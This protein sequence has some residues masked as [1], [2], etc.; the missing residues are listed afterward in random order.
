MQL[1][2]L[3]QG[4]H[5]VVSSHVPLSLARGLEQLAQQN[6]RSV[7]GEIRLALRE[8]VTRSRAQSETPAVHV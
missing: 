1:T 2:T 7:S 4:T 6:E 5:R 3:A 8:H